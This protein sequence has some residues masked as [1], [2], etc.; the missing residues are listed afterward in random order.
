MSPRRRGTGG[1]RGRI[2]WTDDDPEPRSCC[3]VLHFQGK[4]G[5]GKRGETHVRFPAPPPALTASFP[6]SHASWNDLGDNFSGPTSPP[7]NTG[8]TSSRPTP[9]AS[10]AVMPPLRRRLVP[11][12]RP[13]LSARRNARALGARAAGCGLRVS[14]RFAARLGDAFDVRES[15]GRLF[16]P[17][18]ASPDATPSRAA[19]RTMRFVVEISG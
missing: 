16:E 15:R 18:V 14:A 9:T 12:T 3:G 2:Q 6:P 1:T 11:R 10:A 19:C 4:N 13:A 17:D 8:K 5:C 7:G